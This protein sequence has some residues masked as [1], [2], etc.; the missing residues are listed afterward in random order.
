MPDL[1][2]ALGVRPPHEFDELTA[3]ERTHLA[4]ALQAASDRRR[5]QLDESIQASLSHLPRVLR[6]T[7][8]RA[9]GM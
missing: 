8:R 2:S 9:L 7:V 1:T 4:D 5:A 3:D 6:G